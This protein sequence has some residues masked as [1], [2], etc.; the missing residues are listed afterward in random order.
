MAQTGCLRSWR[1]RLGA[2][3]RPTAGCMAETWPAQGARL[4]TRPC[5]CW[6]LDTRRR[7][8][9]PFGSACSEVSWDGPMEATASTGTGTKVSQITTG[10][11]FWPAQME[12]GTTE[13]ATTVISSTAMVNNT[14]FALDVHLCSFL[15]Y[16]PTIPTN[17]QYVWFAVKKI[18]IFNSKEI[19]EVHHEAAIQIKL[20]KLPLQQFYSD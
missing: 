11:A 16:F 18:Y 3:P 4:K 15:L 2:P 9:P 19:H 14:W 5:G 10:P 13:D 12:N 7:V 17:G 6:S 1:W 8:T 20:R